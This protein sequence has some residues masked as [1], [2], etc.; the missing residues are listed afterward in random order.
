[1]GVLPLVGA[2][3][4]VRPA[5]LLQDTGDVVL[6]LTGHDGRVVVFDHDPLVFGLDGIG[7]AAL[8]TVVVAVGSGVE[9]VRQHRADGDGVPRLAG[10]GAD[11]LLV[12]LLCHGGQ[13]LNGLVE[14]VDVEDDLRLVVEDMEDLLL[15]V[16]GIAEGYLAAVPDA[17]VGSR[18]HDGADTLGS[19]VA[20]QLGEDED[21]FQH[22]LAHRRGGVEL[23]VL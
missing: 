18:Q 16:V 2:T 4:E 17:A 7:A 10:T 20:L 12:E 14:V 15:F 8:V 5:T 13:G 19:H 3:I 1:M 21:D 23:L 22:S 11:T 9:R 6:T